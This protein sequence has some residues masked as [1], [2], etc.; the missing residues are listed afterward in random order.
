MH[1]LPEAWKF[2]IP[3]DNG[4]PC[5]QYAYTLKH[6]KQHLSVQHK[7]EGIALDEHCDS[8]RL[9]RDAYER[10]SCGFCLQ[11][12]P[13]PPYDTETRLLVIYG[14]AI[15]ASI[16]SITLR[17]LTGYAS[18]SARHMERSQKKSRKLKGRSIISLDRILKLPKSR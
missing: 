5:H 1:Q 8:M 14:P 6:H 7:L 2:T 17:F 16:S 11:V 13:I 4:R 9:G 10:F 15:S 3:K 12:L 18:S